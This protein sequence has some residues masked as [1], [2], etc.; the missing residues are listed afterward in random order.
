MFPRCKA[1]SSNTNFRSHAQV[2]PFLPLLP[3]P[4]GVHF[5][6]HVAA[7]HPQLCWFNSLWS[8][9]WISNPGSRTEKEK[10]KCGRGE[11]F[12]TGSVQ[13]Q[14]IDWR[15]EVPMKTREQLDAAQRQEWVALEAENP[16]VDG[17]VPQNWGPNHYEIIPSSCFNSVTLLPFTFVCLFI[18]RKSVATPFYLCTTNLHKAIQKLEV[19][20]FLQ[21]RSG[22]PSSSSQL[23]WLYCRN[24]AP[25]P[26]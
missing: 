11:L 3:P 16:V 21:L 22:T 14:G 24:T 26:Q 7:C 19:F 5:C 6:H 20:H 17:F 18:L 2:Y 12:C 25:F 9:W 15:T 1:S 8:I 10:E 4:L 13:F 23:H